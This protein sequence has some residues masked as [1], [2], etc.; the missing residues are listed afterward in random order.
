VPESLNIRLLAIHTRH[1]ANLAASEH[2]RL[3]FALELERI[4]EER[5]FASANGHEEFL[6]QWMRAADYVRAAV[7]G[8][9]F[10]LGVTSWVAPL[11]QRLLARVLSAV[12]PRGDCKSSEGSPLVVGA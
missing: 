12:L 6:S 11:K 5:H 4:F 10:D 2:G 9:D 1:D 7:G 3:V 8:K